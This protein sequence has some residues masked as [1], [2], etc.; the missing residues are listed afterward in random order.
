MKIAIF[1]RPE[2]D[3]RIVKKQGVFYE[4]DGIVKFN[5]GD[6]DSPV[7]HEEFDFMW[8]NFYVHRISRKLISKSNP[9][10][11]LK[12]LLDR[13]VGRVWAEEET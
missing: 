6:S 4:E 3:I 2:K 12:G 5:H 9:K 8:G 1:D 7:S 11:Y 13:F 10:E